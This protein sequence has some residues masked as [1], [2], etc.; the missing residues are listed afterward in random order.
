MT[1]IEF[2]TRLMSHSKYGALTQIFVIDA[3]AKW[4][5]IVVAEGLEK[6]RQV[7]GEHPFVHPDAWFGVAKEIKEAIEARSE[8]ASSRTVGAEEETVLPDL[9]NPPDTEARKS[10]V[11]HYKS[12][13]FTV[14][15]L[16]S[17]NL[18]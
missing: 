9:G 14:A 17:K 16:S 4:S 8:N 11:V 7:F 2:V 12:R 3:L 10:R 18:R 15:Q 6:V 1:N 5:G 13:G